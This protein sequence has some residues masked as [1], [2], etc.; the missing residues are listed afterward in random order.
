MRLN[1]TCADFNIPVKGEI[2]NNIFLGDVHFVM[3]FLGKQQ[4]GGLAVIQDFLSTRLAATQEHTR[5]F[6]TYEIVSLI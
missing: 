3:G 2:S 5:T 1:Q 4:L 6:Q